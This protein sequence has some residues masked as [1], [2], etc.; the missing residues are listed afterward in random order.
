MREQIAG[1]GGLLDS[2]VMQNDNPVS[3]ML[4]NSQVVGHDDHRGPRSFPPDFR[5]CVQNLD[6][7]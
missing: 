2:P 6:T 4:H 7:P 1:G 5:Q 3:N